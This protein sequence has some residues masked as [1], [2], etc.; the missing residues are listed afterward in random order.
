MQRWCDFSGLEEVQSV[1]CDIA[2]Y[3]HARAHVRISPTKGA[4][5]GGG[6]AHSRRSM[7]RCFSRCLIS[8]NRSPGRVKNP[9]RLAPVGMM[10]VP[11]ANQSLC[12]TTLRELHT[13]EKPNVSQL[14]H[15]LC[16]DLRARLGP[17][18]GLE[19]FSRPT[20]GFVAYELEGRG[21]L[22]EGRSLRKGHA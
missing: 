9:G 21:D 16:C 12:P 6:R 18:P 8:W 11:L 4:V 19:E 2:E 1:S 15:V 7:I 5:A 13:V 3:D 14:L 17:D 20:T 10:N 22:R